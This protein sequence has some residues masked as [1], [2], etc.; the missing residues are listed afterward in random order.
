MTLIETTDLSQSE[1]IAFEVDLKHGPAKVWRALTDPVLLE[2]WLLPVVGQK[3]ELQTG[4]AF[5]LQ[6]QANASGLGLGLYIARRIIDLHGGTITVD[7][8]GVGLG[9]SFTVHLP[10]PQPDLPIA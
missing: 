9:T 2:E 3:L 1:S 6:T 7:S 8:P 4:A 10:A 5:T